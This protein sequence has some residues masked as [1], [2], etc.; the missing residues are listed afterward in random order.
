MKTKVNYTKTTYESKLVLYQKKAL[1]LEKERN[2]TYLVWDELKQKNHLE[3]K[4][5]K[6]KILR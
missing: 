6:N 5:M 3:H 1:I 2:T 4:S